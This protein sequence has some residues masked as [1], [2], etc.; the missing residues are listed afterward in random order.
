MRRTVLSGVFAL[1]FILG[2]ADD[3]PGGPGTDATAVPVAIYAAAGS[4]GGPVRLA[5]SGGTAAAVDSIHVALTTVV[6]RDIAFRY[7][8]DTVQVADSTQCVKR[9]RDEYEHGWKDYRVTT[10]FRGPFVVTL[11]NNVPVKIALD[12][13]PPGTYDGITFTLHKLHPKDVSA[14]ST[15]PDSL[16]GYSVVI[17][18]QV[19]YKGDSTGRQFM[20]KADINEAFKVR[21]DFVV[22]A[23][24]NE[25]PYVLDF[26][27][28][29]WFD[30]GSRMLDPNSAFDRR[31]IRWNIKHALKDLMRGG[32]DWN[33]DGHPD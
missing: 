11:P 30:G 27:M 3:N 1:A 32:R 28:D 8:V 5:K 2:C 29:A 18:G 26:K 23:G 16:V 17:F 7:R 10:R 4:A 24:S 14:D 13:I 15:L 25:V 19:F 21:G 31:W 20:F 6:L 22:P 12:T 33:H 9:D